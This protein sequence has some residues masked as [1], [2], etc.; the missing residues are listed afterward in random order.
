MVKIQLTHLFCETQFGETYVLT[1]CS[2]IWLGPE[3]RYNHRGER[4]AKWLQVL[5]STWGGAEEPFKSFNSFSKIHILFESS[6]D[7]WFE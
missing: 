2:Q 5:D 3:K 1:D 6:Q 7:C 4:E